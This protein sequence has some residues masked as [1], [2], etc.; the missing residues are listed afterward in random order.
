MDLT[1]KSSTRLQVVIIFPQNCY[2]ISSSHGHTFT[3]RRDKQGNQ[4]FH[5]FR[6]IVFTP[7]FFKSTQTFKELWKKIIKLMDSETQSD[8]RR[9]KWEIHEEKIKRKH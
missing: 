8:F 2:L 3:I 6:L 9:L 4:L 7:F 5:L 1:G